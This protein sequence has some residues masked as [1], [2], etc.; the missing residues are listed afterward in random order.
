[1]SKL[2]SNDDKNLKFVIYAR[3]STEGEDRQMASLGDQ[4]DIADEIV[5]KNSYKIVRT[6]KESASASKRNNRPKFDEMVKMI[7]SGK[8]NAIICW[9][10]N[11][12]AR[13]PY[14]NGIIQQFLLEQKIQ[15][16]H[17]NDRVYRPGDSAI[18]FSV[19]AGMSAQYSIDLSKNVKRGMHSKNK[20]GGVNGLAP[21]GYLNGRNSDNKPIIEKDPDH[22]LLTQKAFRL[23]LT[24]NYTVPEL[25]QIMN[26]DWHYTTRKRK[27][28]GGKPLSLTGLHKILENPFYMGKIRDYEDPNRFNEGSWEPMITEDE[29]WRVQNIKSKYAQEHKLRPKVSANTKRYE[30]KGLMTCSSCGCSIIAEPH[31]RKL[32]NGDYNEHLYYRCT[33]KSPKRKCELRGGVKQ[34]ELFKQIDDLLDN[35]T[36]HPLLYEWG[37]EI[38]K[39]LKNKE[40]MERY[41]VA[42]MQ[43]ATFKDLE[44]QMH[45]LVSMRTRG[46]IND[47]MFKSQSEELESLMDDIK[48]SNRDIEERNKNW[49][50]VIGKTLETLKAP[51]EEYDQ[52]TC[53]GEKRAV[54]QSIGPFVVLTEKTIKADD[55]EKVLTKKVIEVKPYPWVEI[56][57]NSAKIIGK[58]LDKVLTESQQSKNDLK[59]SL[60]L[61]WSG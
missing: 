12:L 43:H 25:L 5:K 10:T 48:E 40:I 9:Q 24:G 2:A 51:K 30:L 61:Q 53:P 34:E 57:Q 39:D 33:H 52:A 4:M 15:L 55:N 46:L 44:D 8:A 35:H 7:D 32:A 58:K 50:E 1:M 60:Y 19:E 56:L 18:I 22:F 42:K 23:Y 59:R 37:I 47:E 20:D 14:E 31:Q 3:K 13:N 27:K 54:L 49:Y 45:E 26:D 17:T 6:F 16:I 41:D 38:L 28:T 36:I 11:R 21:Q 29:Y